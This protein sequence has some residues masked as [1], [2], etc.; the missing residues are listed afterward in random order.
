MNVPIIPIAICTI[1][2]ACGWYVNVPLFLQL[3]LIDEVLPS[4][5]AAA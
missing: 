1:S 5:C 2:S 4:G 3:K